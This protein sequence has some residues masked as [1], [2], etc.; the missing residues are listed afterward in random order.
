MI[1]STIH[2]DSLYDQFKG[3]SGSPVRRVGHQ[4]TK[5]SRLRSTVLK[6]NCYLNTEADRS[7]AAVI[8]VPEECDTLGEVIPKIHK[9][10]DLN[11]RIAFAAELFLPDGTKIKNFPML[12]DASDNDHAIIVTCGE[13]F[14]PTTVPYDLLEAYLHGGGRNAINKVCDELKVKQK[15]AAHEKADTVR[16]A[17]HGVYPNS[18]AVVTSRSMTV[19]S[20]KEIGDTMRHEYMEQLM[21]RAEQQKKLTTLVQESTAMRKMETKATKERRKEL[22]AERLEDIKAEKKAERE[23]F[24]LKQAERADRIKQKHNA[25]KGAYNEQLKI[26]MATKYSGAEGGIIMPV[27]AER[28]P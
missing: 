19:Q 18:S 12:V 26:K 23:R 2:T 5:T 11:K 8:R 6:L 4:A 17:G 22:E 3:G 15:L 9:A 1:N 27:N 21:F 20:N 10:L 24:L 16:S 13:A 28:S 7:R 14:D 25:I